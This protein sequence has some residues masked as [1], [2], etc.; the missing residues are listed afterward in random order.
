MKEGIHPRYE[1]VEAVCACGNK[2]Q[3]RSTKAELKLEIC[4][5]CHPFYTGEVRFTDATGRIDR[6]NKRFAKTDGKMALR[7]APKKAPPKKVLSVVKK[8]KTLTTAPRQK[9]EKPPK[10]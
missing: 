1:L 5:A 7:K 8:E 3:T 4:G 6:F 2:F 10:K 9:A